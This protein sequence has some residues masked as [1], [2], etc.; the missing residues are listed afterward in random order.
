MH[1]WQTGTN[2]F[3]HFLFALFAS[4]VAPMSSQSTTP[5]HSSAA[6]APTSAASSLQD[7]TKSLRDI[8]ERHMGPLLHA[9]THPSAPPLRAAQARAGVALMLAKIRYMSGRV[10][11]GTVLPKSNPLRQDLDQ[12]RKLVA[13]TMKKKPP[14]E[15][16]TAA[17]TTSTADSNSSSPVNKKTKPASASSAVTST[18]VDETNVMASRTPPGK[19]DKKTTTTA[20]ASTGSPHTTQTNK[21]NKKRK[22]GSNDAVAFPDDD[23]PSPSK[24]A[25]QHQDKR[26]RGGGK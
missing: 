6:P 24:R 5:G 13:A 14:S 19:A 10:R 9:A 11:N 23:V 21:K 12:I 15:T 17:S 7:V 2:H 8:Q 25:S 22:S 26:P 16:S 4:L 1:D 18:A 3:T 20:T